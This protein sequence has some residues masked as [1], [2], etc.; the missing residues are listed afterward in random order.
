MANNQK[1]Y[2][3]GAVLKNLAK[4]QRTGT[5]ICVGDDQVQGRI[6]LREGRPAMARCRHLQGREAVER[7]NENLLVSLKFHND[8]NL[9]TLKEDE[10]F[11]TDITSDNEPADGAVTQEEVDTMSLANS[12]NEKEFEVA[13]TAELRD[14]VIEELT[15]YL[16]PVAGI[17]ADDLRKGLTLAEVLNILSS[18][19]GDTDAAIEFVNKVRARI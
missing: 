8:I 9:V 19:I 17:F 18:E 2:R 11:I 5:L 16:G 3:L 4:D 13:F 6:Y 10:A 15:E 12:H 7:I 14:I 1:K